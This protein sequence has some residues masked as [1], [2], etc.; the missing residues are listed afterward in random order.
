MWAAAVFTLADV[1]DPQI[2]DGPRDVSETS[3]VALLRHLRIMSE[4]RGGKVPTLCYAMVLPGR[5][6]AFRAGFWPDCYLER[7][8][9]GPPAGRRLAG[10]PNS[11]LSR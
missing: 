5:K 4:R 11:V 8:E 3:K 1:P 6:S 2:W 7:T 9:I 10:G